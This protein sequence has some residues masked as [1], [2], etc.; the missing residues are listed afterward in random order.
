V[1]SLRSRIL[2]FPVG[3]RSSIVTADAPTQAILGLPELEA[4]RDAATAIARRIAAIVLLAPELDANDRALTASAA[5]F[6]PHTG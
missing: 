2:L 5:P 1:L 4:E 6:P 3:L